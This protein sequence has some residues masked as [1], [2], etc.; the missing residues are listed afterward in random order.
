ML[1]GESRLASRFNYV[2]NL[3]HWQAKETR[4]QEAQQ[5][6]KELPIQRK[7]RIVVSGQYSLSFS[8]SPAQRFYRTFAVAYRKT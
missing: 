5:M 7:E 3:R 4:E 8:P 2:P 6:E 1:S